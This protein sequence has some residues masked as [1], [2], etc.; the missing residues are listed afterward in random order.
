MWYLIE[1]SQKKE[2]SITQD[3][4]KGEQESDGD[5]DGWETDDE[6][7]YVDNGDS[8]SDGWVDVSHS[9]D[10]QPNDDDDEEE[11]GGI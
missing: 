3:D 1:K 9:E 4:N 7:E 11:E 8:E 10:E 5:D 2:K 6:V